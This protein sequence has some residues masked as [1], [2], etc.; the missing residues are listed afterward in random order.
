M[1]YPVLGC[2]LCTVACIACGT[3]ILSLNPSLGGRYATD[4]LMSFCWENY[5]YGAIINWIYVG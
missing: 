4:Y 3:G 5:Y 1:H 2:P